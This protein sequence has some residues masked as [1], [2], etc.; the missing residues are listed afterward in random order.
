MTLE[1]LSILRG[2]STRKLNYTNIR[3]P[4]FFV[5]LCIQKQKNSLLN[6]AKKINNLEFIDLRSIQGRVDH[7]SDPK[8]VNL[9]CIGF[10]NAFSKS[11]IYKYS[12]NYKELT[13]ILNTIKK[14]KKIIPYYNPKKNIQAFTVYHNPE[15]LLLKLLYGA[16]I[17]CNMHGI[18]LKPINFPSKFPLEAGCDILKL[19]Y[20]QD[21]DIILNAFDKFGL[22]YPKFVSTQSFNSKEKRKKAN[23]ITRIVYLQTIY[24]AI[25]PVIDL[26]RLKIAIPNAK[27]KLHPRLSSNKVKSIF[28]KIISKLLGEF[29]NECE[30]R[31]DT[32]Y[33]SNGSTAL[34]RAKLSGCNVA[35]YSGTPKLSNPYPNYL[36]IK[37]YKVK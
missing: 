27:I 15:I 10:E 3:I 7:F 16:K 8:S 4:K 22:N 28:F 13:Y 5:N 36:N 19:H 31:H 11:T 14:T 9:N 26:L 1:T 35:F 25:N 30:Y 12:W 34:L 37:N 6:L 29:V 20:E 23:Q 24:R 33:I 17:T 2:L 21:K 32:L 18:A